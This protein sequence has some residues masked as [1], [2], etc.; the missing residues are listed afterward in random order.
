MRTAIGFFRLKMSVSRWG[1]TPIMCGRDC[2][3][4]RRRV[5]RR[6]L[7]A[8]LGKN[9]PDERPRTIMCTKTYLSINWRRKGNGFVGI[10]LSTKQSKRRRSPCGTKLGLAAANLVSGA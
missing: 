10:D 4:G 9:S 1:L 7:I 2:V 5:D 8:K 6:P 3:G